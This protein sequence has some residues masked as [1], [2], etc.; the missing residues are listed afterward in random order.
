[1]SWERE[2]AWNYQ[3]CPEGRGVVGCSDGVSSRLSLWLCGP[4][5][6]P[7]QAKEN[8]QMP[9]KVASLTLGKVALAKQEI[10]CVVTFIFCWQSKEKKESFQ[11]VHRQTKAFKQWGNLVWNDG[12]STWFTW[13]GSSGESCSHF[14]N[15]HVLGFRAETNKPKPVLKECELKGGARPVQNGVFLLLEWNTK[16]GCTG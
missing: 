6:A 9:W 11:V 8:L 7:A 3:V 16:P 10:S 14:M 5:W 12:I 15:L 2:W 4:G 1:M 13:C